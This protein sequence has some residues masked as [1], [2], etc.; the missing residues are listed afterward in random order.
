MNRKP[1]WQLKLGF[2]ITGFFLVG[3]SKSAMA[4]SHTVRE[5]KIPGGGIAQI[6]LDGV[7]PKG[8]LEFDYVRDIVQLS[9]QNATIYP[10]KILHSE[11]GDEAFSKVFAYQ[12]APNLV[13]IRF[14]VGGKADVYRGKVKLEQKGKILTVRFPDAIVG[15]RA[16]PDRE[17]SLLAKVLGQAASV[18]SPVEEKVAAQEVKAAKPVEAPGNDAPA[19]VIESKPAKLTGTRT[20]TAPQLGGAKS[21]VS[22]MRSLFAMFLVVGGLGMVLLYVK[23]RKK[24]APGKRNGDSW[25]SQVL[26]GAKRNTSYIEVLASHALGPKQSI[27]VVRIRDQKFVLGVTQDSVQLITQ[28]DSDEADLDV[29][30]DPMVADSIGKLFGSKP[31]G[32]PAAPSSVL[33]NPEPAIK[34]PEPAIDLGA[35][36]NSL[37]K[38]STGAG[39]VIAR[40]AYSQQ[41]APAADSRVQAQKGGGIRN[42]L[43][44]QVQEMGKI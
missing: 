41:Q 8:A 21:G 19:P 39:A 44:Q 42:R 23:S 6:H 11:S 32:I 5:V 34:I 12:Y 31:K 10:A 28:L 26:S 25:F 27:T 40:S 22:A 15:S 29:L 24:G 4:G 16:L 33:L 37:L 17:Q 18:G 36:F 2:F 38:S 30:E 35:S 9:I 13:R 1:G 43:R 7:P 3:A 20:P 14:T